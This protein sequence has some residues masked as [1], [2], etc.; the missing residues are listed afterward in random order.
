[1]VE[2]GITADQGKLS[3]LQGDETRMNAQLMSRISYVNLEQ[4]AQ[5]LGDS[6][7]VA[8]QAWYDANKDAVEYVSTTIPV[9]LATG[10]DKKATA[11]VD[12]SA[13]AVF[14]KPFAVADTKLFVKTAEALPEWRQQMVAVHVPDLL[15]KITGLPESMASNLATVEGIEPASDGAFTVSVSAP[16]PVAIVQYQAQQAAKSYGSGKIWGGVSKGEFESRMA[17]VTDIPS[18]VGPPVTTQATVTVE[19]TGDGDYSETS[20]P[21][22]D[23]LA[24]QVNRYQVTLQS[25]SAPDPASVS[26]A[27]AKAESDAIKS[28]DKQVIKKQSRPGTKRLVGGGSGQSLTVKSNFADLHVTFFKWGTKTQTVSVFVQAGKSLKFRIPLGTY[29]VVFAAGATWYGPKYS[30]GPSGTYSELK[31]SPSST[32]PLKYVVKRNYYYTLTFGTPSGNIGGGG[33]DNPYEK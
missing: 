15:A 3:A 4:A 29:R 21:L 7:R 10:S 31:S 28:L 1:V 18:D 25:S 20:A 33:I 22:S 26:E 8:W 13:L 2:S 27:R 17:E 30:F 11:A 32:S 23:I 5:A 12:K 16:D 24:K 19:A 14:L 9:T 6:G